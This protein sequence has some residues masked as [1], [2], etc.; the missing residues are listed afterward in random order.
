MKKGAKKISGIVY[1]PSVTETL[2]SMAAGDVIIAETE[3]FKSVHLVR[4]TA[5][6]LGKGKG[7]FKVN[8]LDNGARVRIERLNVTDA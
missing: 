1:V 5:A 2:R 8:Q 4:E 3:K 7:L 6:W